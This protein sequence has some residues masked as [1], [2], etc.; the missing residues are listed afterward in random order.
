MLRA[1]DFWAEGLFQPC[2]HAGAG[3]ARSDNDNASDALQIVRL[4]AD[5]QPIPGDAH[6]I[7][8]EHARIDSRDAGAPDLQGIFA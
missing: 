7:T 5:V 2:R 6:G 8:D 4:V 1:E 3:F